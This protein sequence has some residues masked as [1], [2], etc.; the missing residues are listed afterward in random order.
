MLLLL[1]RLNT[2]LCWIF[3]IDKIIIIVFLSQ[4]EISKFLLVVS[5][6]LVG[7]KSRA[8]DGFHSHTTILVDRIAVAVATRGFSSQSITVVLVDEIV[9]TGIDQV[10]LVPR[11]IVSNKSTALGWTIEKVI[12]KGIRIATRFRGVDRGIQ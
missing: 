11:P 8:V 3:L 10:G 4:N 5:F 1:S 7:R 9:G 2:A 12:Q 6:K